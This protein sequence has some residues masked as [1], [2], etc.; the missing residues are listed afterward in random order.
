MASE[1]IPPKNRVLVILDHLGGQRPLLLFR[2]IEWAGIACAQALLKKQYCRIMV[3]RGEAAGY[4]HFQRTIGELAANNTV[5]AIDVII[6][7]H[8]SSGYLVFARNTHVN[9]KDIRFAPE[10]QHKLRL[11]YSTACYA[12][13]GNS[14]WLNA[15]F[16]T[17]IG[18]RGINVNAFPEYPLLLNAWA[19]GASIAAACGAANG[20][21]TKAPDLP[22]RFFNKQVNSE[23]IVAGNRELTINSVP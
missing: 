13:T 8:G 17:A 20:G 23:K 16:K 6:N 15:G 2:F 5:K 9:Y 21:L 12:A 22:G 18:A 11:L 3:L 7:M 4:A 1:Q 10:A 14:H 19:K